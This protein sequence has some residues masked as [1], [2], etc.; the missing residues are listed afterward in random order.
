MGEGE[1]WHDAW[2]FGRGGAFNVSITF[3]PN[4]PTNKDIM[5]VPSHFHDDTI[6]QGNLIN[7][8]ENKMSLSSSFPSQ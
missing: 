8:M 5:H 3:I 7:T 1:H 2:S 4:F 6:K